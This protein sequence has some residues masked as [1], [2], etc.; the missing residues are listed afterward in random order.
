[1]DSQSTQ[2]IKLPILQPEN[3][4]A[5]IVT[6]IVDGKETV[7]PR[8]SVEE[9]AQRRAEL[10]ER[11]PLFGGNIATKKTQKNLSKQQY[12][13]FAASSTEVIEQTY[14]RL[15]KLISQL[16]MHEIETLSLD[17]IFNNLKAYESEVMGISRSTTNS[18][19]VAFL[20][21]SSTN[22]TTRAVNTAQG[23]NTAS[24]QGAADS[25]TTVENLSD[26]VIYSFFTSQP[27]CVKDLKEQNEQLVKD[28]RKTKISDVSYKTGLESVEVR[29]L[30]FKKNESVYEEDIKLLK[31]KIY[32]MDKCKKR[33]G[34]NAVPPSYTENFMPPKPDLVYPS[35][36]DF[37]DVNKSISE[38]V[39]EKPTVESNE[40]KT[41]SK[42]NEA[43]IIKDWGT[44]RVQ[45]PLKKISKQKVVKPF[46]NYNQ[47]VN[48]RNFATNTQP[49]PKRNIVPRAVLIKSG[50]KSV[51]A[52]RQNF[53]KATVTLNTARLVNTVQ[54]RTTVNNVGAIK[55]VIN[56]AYSTARR[57]ITNR[58]T[59]KN[60]KINQK[61]NTVRATHVNTAR[62]KVNTAR[63]KVKTAR[64]KVNTV[65]GN[66]V[67][68]VKASACWVWSPKHKVLDHVSRNNGA[69]M[70]FKRFD[71]IDA[72][73][74]SK[75]MT[76][77]KSYLTDYE[78]IDGGSFAFGGEKQNL[79]ES[80]TCVFQ[81]KIVELEKT[82]AKQTKENSDLLMNIDNLENAFV[83]EVKRGHSIDKIKVL[84]K[85]TPNIAG[86][87][88]NWIF[89]IDALTKSMNYKIVVARN[90]SN[91][92]AGEEEKKDAK[93]LGNKDSE[94][95]STKEPRVNQENNEN[96]NSTNNINTVSPT[97]NAAGIEN[98]AVD[99]N[100]VYGCAD[101]PNMPDLEG[102]GRFSDVE[103][104]YSGA[105]MNNFD[106]YFQVS[107][108]PTTRIHKDHTLEQV[109]RD[110]HLAPQTRRMSKNLEEHGLVSTVK[111]KTNHKDLQNC[112][113]ACFLS[114]IEPKKGHTQ[115]EGIDY[116]EIF[117]LAARIK[118]IML[119]LAYA[120][121]K[122]FMVY[123][124][125]V[126]SAFLYEKIEEEV[127][128]CQSLGF[129][130]PDFHDKVYKVEKVLYGLHQ[131]PR[132]WGKRSVLPEYFDRVKQIGERN[133]YI[134]DLIDFGV[135]NIQ[136]L[137]DLESWLREGC[138]K[139]N[140]KAV[141]DEIEMAN[142]TR[143]YVSPSHTK[144][145][146][147]NIKRVGKG[148]SGRDTPLFPT[149]MVQAQEE[150]GEDIVIPTETHPTPI[151]TQPSSSQPS[152]KQKPRKTKRQDTELPQTSMPT[153]TVADEAVNEEIYDSL[154]R[155]TTTAT[156]LD[157]DHD[158]GNIS[159][160]KSKATPNEPSSPRTSSGGG[161]R[162]QDTMG[163]TIAETRKRRLRTHGLKRLYK[164]R[165]SARV[166][167]SADEESLGEE[168]SSKHGRIYDIIANKDIYLVYVYRD[169]DIFDVNDQDDTLMFDTDKDLQGK[170][171]VVKN[172][173]G[174]KTS[175]PKAKVI[176][177]QEPSE[178]T[179][180]TI[181][182]LIKYQ[183]KGKGI[184]IE[185]EMPLKKK[186]QISHDEKFAFKLQAKKD[187]QER[188]IREKAQQIKEVNLAWD[189]V[190]AK[191][192]ADY[193]M[194]QR[195]QA[196]EQEQLTDAEKVRLFMEFLE[197]RRKFFAAKRAKEKRNKPPTKAQQR[198]LISII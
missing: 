13:N 50:I 156:C 71:Y 34:Y 159:K 22:S 70:S 139:W 186:A 146:F 81:I 47:R 129:E 103:N 153:E 150:L 2:T 169:E 154:E 94:V 195:L 29:L 172:T 182:P 41:T 135:Y 138:L 165:L 123:Q 121:F 92:S 108:V 18:H 9:K 76:G 83:D 101:D 85:N 161:P 55:N 84:S 198:S 37:V 160:T 191:I 164:V 61:V 57:P 40:P 97:D 62:P 116:D 26:A 184:I 104:D 65:Q 194:A 21:S 36:D 158:R 38:S 167:S 77:N 68:A 90:Q 127:Y 8:T 56:K 136:D 142:H 124:M 74:I 133:V 72:Q 152:R 69:S 64:P 163:D 119:F 109:I 7:I 89:D 144:K 189:D 28:L 143:I 134:Q 162:R 4:N 44:E 128:V 151:I 111:Q 19:N 180:T 80:K 177:M 46:W 5:P 105:E 179:T 147:E 140:G 67:N 99:E 155:A 14:K 183:D 11:S 42:E 87:G 100:I 25:S 166:E 79:F 95:P 75:H 175:K 1:M 58:T 12:E 185:P 120:S 174:N 188:I 181:I 173:C 112:L 197:K 27:K 187:E 49:C 78:E 141:K 86:S 88:P 52:A 35:L 31:Y 43:P 114:Q 98:N 176:V 23:V 60:S 170:E 130:D 115:K 131:A 39:V 132:A 16:E 113:F 125:D 63:P 54:P 145:I 53:T 122:D 51:N 6:K 45:L 15:Q 93:D 148:F 193:E 3:G 73:G 126:K 192:N 106:T 118:A 107:P 20:S 10:K 196:K 137:I 30:V 48:H 110:L 171:V 32:I 66:H 168:D 59:S 117:A 33:L 96:V 149:M 24:T 157:A 178:A 82:L 91:S 102:I 190:Q 17:E